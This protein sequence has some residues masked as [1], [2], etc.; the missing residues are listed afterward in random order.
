LLLEIENQFAEKKKGKQ[1]GKYFVAIDA[2][3]VSILIFAHER[4]T[5][6]KINDFPI[7]I[8]RQRSIVELWIKESKQRVHDH[9]SE[10]N[11]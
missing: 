4:V 9:S 8:F 2:T 3:I 10:I 1:I 7:G 11:S 6:I 5:T